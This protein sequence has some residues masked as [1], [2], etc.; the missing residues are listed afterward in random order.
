[1]IIKG[2]ADHSPAGLPAR[3]VIVDGI[4]RLQKWVPRD[5]PELFGRLDREVRA[6]VRFAQVYKDLPYPWELPRLV[7]Y[8]VDGEEPFALLEPYRGVPVRGIGLLSMAARHQFQVGVLRAV[9]HAGAAAIVHRQINQ[10]T[11]RWDQNAGTVHLVDFENAARIGEPT[12]IGRSVGVADPGTDV[13][14]AALVIHEVIMGRSSGAVPDLT[15]DPEGLRDLLTGVFVE[16]PAARPTVTELLDRLQADTTVR[17]VN[18]RDQLEPGLQAFEQA[19]ERKQ[20]SYPI[21][22]QP[23][24]PPPPAPRSRRRLFGRSRQEDR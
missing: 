10:E 21:P 17:F 19:R 6:G 5:R 20:R 4:E 7:A 14:D 23:V 22:E 2:D 3:T 24:T 15:T 9:L 11:V 18:L 1:M 8:D 13:W 12:P 16:P